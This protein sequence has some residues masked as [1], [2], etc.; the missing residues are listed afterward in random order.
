LFKKLAE[1]EE[2]R[3]T[4]AAIRFQDSLRQV[5]ALAAID[6]WKVDKLVKAELAS[7][8]KDSTV[9]KK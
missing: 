8:N 2:E 6:Q 4:A 7:R 9:R 5:V 3:T 1:R